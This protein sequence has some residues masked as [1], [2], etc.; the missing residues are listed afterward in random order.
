MWCS[1]PSFESPPPVRERRAADPELMMAADAHTLPSG[2]PANGRLAS[3]AVKSANGLSVVRIGDSADAEI[4]EAGRAG[5]APT[6]SSLRRA[7]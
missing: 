3:A 7:R 6:V 2:R 4:D 1:P 5:P